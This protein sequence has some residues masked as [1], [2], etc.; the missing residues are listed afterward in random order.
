[1]DGFDEYQKL[2][3]YQYGTYSFILLSVLT[4]VNYF[5]SFIFEIQWA[6]TKE[7]EFILL[8]FGTA[9]YFVAMSVYK[10][11]YFRKK[12]RPKVNVFLFTL[13]GLAH[14]YLS[15]SY[16]TPIILEGYVTFNS[17]TLVPGLLFISIPLAYLTRVAVEKRNDV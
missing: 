12:Q 1:M 14:I 5:L 15:I 2:I 9:V 17:I 8:A 13:I 16:S 10:G 3:R 4:F 6:E 7:L 11:A